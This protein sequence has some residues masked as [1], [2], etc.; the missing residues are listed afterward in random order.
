MGSRSKRFLDIP[1][2]FWIGFVFLVSF[3]LKLIYD[4]QVG[5]SAATVN[6][7]V[8][9]EMVNGLPNEGHVGYMQYLFTYHRYPNTDPRGYA[10]FIDPPFYY[11]ICALI[12]EL[13]HR[14]MRWPIGT[15]LH[16]LQCI[17]VI[18]V[19]IGCTHMISMLH[20]F[21]IRG[22]K[23][24]VCILFIS[25]FPGFYHLGA[26]LSPNAMSF[27]F[28][29]GA[30]N[31]GLS[32]YGSR[33]QKPFL[34]AALL[35]ALG[36]LTAWQGVLA[37]PALL[38]LYYYAAQD[39]RRNEVS[40]ARQMMRALC[41]LIPSAFVWP[42]YRYIRF[43]IPFFY[44]QRSLRPYGDVSRYS[45][46]SR[47]RLPGKELM[48]DLHTFGVPSKEYNLWAQIFK[49]AIVNFQSINFSRGEARVISEF[50][51]RLSIFLCI[52]FHVMWIYTMFTARIEQPL[53]RFLQVGYLS[54]I[55][56]Y[57]ISCIRFPYI[58]YMNFMRIAPVLLFPVTGMGICGYGLSTDTVFE[59][60]TG[61]AAN[62][63]VLIFALTCAFIFG[64]YA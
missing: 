3:L 37:V 2:E 50:A 9:K 27:M 1:D 63:L 11:V 39:G 48:R 25:F 49:T 29:M 35:L 5:Y 47:L 10:C 22:R 57:I 24:V 14:L 53:K 6:A 7:G 33:R 20:K 32:W 46:F 17:N 31:H 12:L 64:F 43:H 44:A 54:Y 60:V 61:W 51:F 38:T 18:Y 62:S 56:I 21:G 45:L 41:F 58:Y 13:I 42:F 59:K 52:L 26:E 19:T 30:L 28:S 36:L 34:V 23:L 15:S 40:P 16:V 4:I 8:W 55:L